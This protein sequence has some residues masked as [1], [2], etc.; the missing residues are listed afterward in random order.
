M[1]TAHTLLMLS[2]S[3]IFLFSCSRDYF[4][5]P[6]PPYE[7]EPLE[8]ASVEFATAALFSGTKICFAASS[9][10]DGYR[11]AYTYDDQN[12]LVKVE[13]T[14]SGQTLSKS[15]LEFQSETEALI[16]TTEDDE[17]WDTLHFKLDKGRVSQV[18]QTYLFDKW[19]D[20]QTAYGALDYVTI[21]LIRNAEGYVIQWKETRETHWEKPGSQVE[22]TVYKEDHTHL[23]QNLI[24]TVVTEPNGEQSLTITYE[25]FTDKP[26]TIPLNYSLTSLVIKPSKNLL[27]KKTYTRT[28][29]QGST[30]T[31]KA[32][33]SYEFNSDG[34]VTKQT[35]LYTFSDGGTGK[36]VTSFD[37]MCK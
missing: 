15:F 14:E 24:Q 13:V 33:Y 11:H 1:K 5:D 17:Y 37:H 26:N 12:R 25:Y 36:T 4:D 29:G 6:I 20:N 28:D 30:I 2:L 3:S 27:K 22:T 21:D 34:F 31:E 18:K 19:D 7:E 8:E 16:R 32:E 35:E 23:N 10:E 9:E